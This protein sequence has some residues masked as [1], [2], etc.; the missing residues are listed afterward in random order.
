VVIL[1]LRLGSS[2]GIGTCQQIMAERPETKGIVLTSYAED[3]TVFAAMRA[4]AADYVLKQAGG[5]A[6]VSAIK[7]VGE[8]KAWLDAA[9]TASVLTALGQSAPTHATDAFAGLNSRERRVLTLMANGL[10]NRGIA[11]QLHLGEGTI[12]N[13]VSAIFVKLRVANRA[14]AAAFA[15]KH[16][17]NDLYEYEPSPVLAEA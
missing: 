16:Y 3:E 10:T 2:N 8:S 12:R 17:L 11:E 13:Y 9:L 4:G 1:D 15:T 6:V 14:E 5:Q 7:T